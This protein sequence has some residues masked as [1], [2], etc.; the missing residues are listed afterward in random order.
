MN[1]SEMDAGEL[2]A[3]ARRRELPVDG[4]YGKDKL[5][6]ALEAADEREKKSRRLTKEAEARADAKNGAEFVEVRILPLGDGKV[7]TGQH[8]PG[9]GDVCYARGQNAK[10]LPETAAALEKRGFVEV[11]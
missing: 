11:L 5:I 9:V 7:S 10:L 1:Y 4:R 8:Q 6:I 2:L 3:E